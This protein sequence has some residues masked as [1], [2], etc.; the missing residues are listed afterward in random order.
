MNTTL[1]TVALGALCCRP[2]C[3][4]C[5]CGRIADESEPRSLVVGTVGTRARTSGHAAA[6]D[7]AARSGSLMVTKDCSAYT[8]LAGSFC[9]VTASNLKAIDVGARIVYAQASGATALDSDIVLDLPG[10]G[11]NK[12]FGNELLYFAT[13]TGMCTFSGGTGQFTWFEAR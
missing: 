1:R 3:G 13:G 10:L 9:T 2:P 5:R 12:A 11:N 8:G 6:S 4:L 7:A